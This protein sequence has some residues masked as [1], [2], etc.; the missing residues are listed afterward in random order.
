MAIKKFENI[1]VGRVVK[2]L[3]S[4]DYKW[5]KQ[6]ESGATQGFLYLF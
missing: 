5:K 4:N 6:K 3:D 2:V 1:Q